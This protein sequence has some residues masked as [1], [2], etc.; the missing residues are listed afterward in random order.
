MTENK[1]QKLHPMGASIITGSQRFVLAMLA[2]MFI[3]FAGVASMI[4]S[5]LIENGSLARIAM[6]LIFP[7]G[8]AMVVINETKLFTGKNLMIISVLDKKHTAIQMFKYWA[9]IYCGN[10]LGSLLTTGLFTLGHVYSMFNNK[11]AADVLAFATTKCNIPFAD[12][13]IKGIFCNVL[14][15]FAVKMA[16]KG[17][18]VQGKIIALYIPIMVFVIC[19]FE[20]SIANMSFIS[21][22]LFIDAAYGDLGVATEGLTWFNFFLRNLLPVTLGNTAGGCLVGFVCWFTD[23]DRMSD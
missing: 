1:K 16:M 7:T 3:A 23:A 5:T 6:G 11:L 20:H 15:C 2:G 10:L 9:I 17:T 13:F 12:A 8:L 19:G 21:G 14:V 22:G 18:S 4:A